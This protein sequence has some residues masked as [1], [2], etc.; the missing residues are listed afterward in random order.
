[1]ADLAGA[2]RRARER[3]YAPYSG[4]KVGCALE[5]ADGSVFEGCNVENASFG[6]AMCAERVAVGAAV[7]A[8][9][10]S[11]TR[12]LV[13]TA[14]REPVAPCGACRQ[15]LIEFGGG[16]EIVSMTVSGRT[17]SWRLEEL[18]PAGFELHESDTA[19]DDA[20]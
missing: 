9:H 17:A 8:G 14:G 10:R 18:L 7:A 4:Y 3:A 11:F 20:T 19:N 2:A 15:V 16:V 6:L 12:L 13:M 5:T 1:M